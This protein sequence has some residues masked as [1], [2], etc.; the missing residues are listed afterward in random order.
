MELDIK[1]Y[2]WILKSI[3]LENDWEPWDN[4]S[5]NWKDY[6]FSE[7]DDNYFIAEDLIYTEDEWDI[8]RE[9]NY[10]TTSDT[11]KNWVSNEDLIYTYDTELYYEYDNNL[12][13]SLTNCEYYS[14]EDDLA[15]VYDWP[16]GDWYYENCYVY[17]CNACGD[18]YHEDDWCCN[19]L[20]DG[21][22]GSSSIHILDSENSEFRFWIEIEKHDLA[23]QYT[24]DNLKYHN[25]RCEED[26][27]VD[28]WEY[29]TPILPFTEKWIVW[30]KE[31]GKDII[32][33]Y[34]IDDK[35]GWH[36]HISSSNLNWDELYKNIEHYRQILWGIYP[37]RAENTYCS[38]HEGIY[39][40]YRDVRIHPSYDTLEFRIFPWLDSLKQVDFRLAI[41]KFFLYNPANS[42][43]KAL[44]ILDKKQ[45]EFINIL[46]IVY[47]SLEKKIQVIDR[48]YKFYEV[49]ETN[50]KSICDRA[51]TICESK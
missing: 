14:D 21:N 18:N 30:L 23:S 51:K 47:K 40:K 49:D 42:K 41:L 27:S 33:H 15:Y 13:Y 22:H 26:W 44:N 36:I 2:Y 16:Q 39:K 46:D 50:I 6:I 45:V 12:Y 17:Y 29:I 20:L 8:Y 1:T 24:I 35:C 11:Y 31:T 19:T 38:R 37:K 10:Y 5:F 7:Y 3:E 48:I 43:E 34:G 25:W 4:F 28:G 9:N 32:E